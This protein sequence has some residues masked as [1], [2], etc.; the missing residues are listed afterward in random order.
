MNQYFEAKLTLLGPTLSC[1]DHEIMKRCQ[2]IGCA[3]LNSLNFRVYCA[4]IFS[5]WR[6]QYPF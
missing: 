6:P 3:T 4:L 1:Y 5:G 2:A